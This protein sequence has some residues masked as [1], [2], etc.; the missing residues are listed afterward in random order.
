MNNFP[1]VAFVSN[2]TFRFWKRLFL[3]EKREV[4]RWTEALNNQTISIS[5]IS[6]EKKER[7]RYIWTLRWS[8]EC[9]KFLSL[10]LPTQTSTHSHTRTRTHTHY[11]KHI[12]TSTRS[13]S[14]SHA[15]THARTHSLSLSHCKAI[16]VW[17]EMLLKKSPRQ[18]KGLKSRRG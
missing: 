3:T 16:M 8:P 1:L 15:H 2:K 11:H 9:D 7:S 4:K 13:L 12:Q 10:P 17:S 18:E 6:S 5:F 14:L